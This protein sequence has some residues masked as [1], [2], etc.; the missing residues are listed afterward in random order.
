MNENYAKTQCSLP[1]FISPLPGLLTSSNYYMRIKNLMNNNPARPL[2]GLSTSSI[3]KAGLKFHGLNHRIKI[4][5]P[6]PGLLT[7][8]Y[9][10]RES[11]LYG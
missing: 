8:S 11:K 9:Y 4:D 1:T 6:L 7:S 3:I 5:S 2:P 10:I